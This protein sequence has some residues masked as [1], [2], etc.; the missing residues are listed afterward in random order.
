[1]VPSKLI[2]ALLLLFSSVSFGAEGGSANQVLRIPNA[3]GQ[4]KYG[5]VDL[6]KSAAVGSSVL[7]PANGG[8]VPENKIIN[9]SF[10]FW[11]RGTSFGTGSGSR[12]TADKFRTDSNVTTNSSDR[13]VFT[14]GQTDVPNEPAYYN[15]FTVTSSAGAA[16]NAYITHFIE[17]VRT[18]AGQTCTFSF[19]AKANASR[20]IAVEWN[21]NF[22][23]GGSPSSTVTGIGLTTYALTTTFKKFTTTI[24]FPS[25]SGKTIGTTA[26][27]SYL[28]LRF[29]FD[30]GSNFSANCSSIGQQSG[31]YGLSNIGLYVG[32]N[33]PADFRPAGGSYAGELA[34]AQRY[35]EKSYD[36][37]V[38]PGTA[39]AANY[40]TLFVGTTA[41]NGVNYGSVPYRVTK[42]V[43]NSPT[44]WSYGGS[45][46]AVSDSAGSGFAANSG[47][48]QGATEN[49]FFARNNSGGS[50]SLSTAGTIIFQWAVDADF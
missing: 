23:S 38:A 12:Y 22:G 48:I 16:N 6:S 11:Q 41:A 21:Q 9:G 28:M 20:T 46:T 49:S 8:F 5:S 45:A 31:T 2:A 10:N 43:A 3:G 19:Y 35:Y 25:I 47:A 40:W 42:R 15:Q 17:D 24:S 34:L 4:P 26:N 32:S 33:S 29:W 14:A 18:C 39:S 27:T 1:M 37:A 44:V 13:I 36:I 30:C 50:L 7:A